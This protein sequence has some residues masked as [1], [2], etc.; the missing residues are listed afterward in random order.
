MKK[1]LLLG[2]V[3]AAA[4]C[5]VHAQLFG[6]PGFFGGFA[7]G[8]TSRPTGMNTFGPALRI[9]Y[10]DFT[11]TLPGDI[12]GFEMIGR[13]NTGAP[14]RVYYEIRTGMSEGNGG[15]LLF[16]G[17]TPS[18]A[19]GDLP[20]G[21]EFGTPPPGTGNYRWYGGGPSSLIHLEPGTYWIG[22]APLQQFGSFDAASTQGLQA[23][24]LPINNGNAFYFDSSDP[25]ANFVSL[26]DLDFR[27]RV[28]TDAAVVPERAGTAWFSLAA[29]G[30]CLGRRHW[31]LRHLA[32]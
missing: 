21:G 6:S 3:C 19:A 14:V 25:A 7:D 24:G 28:A 27:L 10:D 12:N 8:V 23:V 26:G 16:S 29:V 31:T 15:T 9:V 11:F 20:L 32:A 4:G 22:L 5:S 30:F 18:A 1:F 17:T 2:A 13:D